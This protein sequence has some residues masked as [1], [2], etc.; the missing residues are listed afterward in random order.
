VKL[1]AEK[2][3]HLAGRIVDRLLDDDLVDFKMPEPRLRAG[4]AH[5][6]EEDLRVEDEIANEAIA[7]IESYKR[8][9]PYGSDEWRLLFERFFR[10][11]AERRG[12]VS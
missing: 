4:L 12:Y 7:K 11:I 9:I 10:E 1:T 3:E 8:E 2:I 6:L 5:V